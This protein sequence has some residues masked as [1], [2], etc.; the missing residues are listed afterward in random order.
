MSNS[1]EE[2]AI[3][4]P[5][6]ISYPQEEGHWKELIPGVRL[7]PYQGTICDLIQQENV[8]L[9]PDCGRVIHPTHI[10]FIRPSTYLYRV[11]KR[12][13]TEGSSVPEGAVESASSPDI[14]RQCLIAAILA[15]RNGGSF[16]SVF[17]FRRRDGMWRTT[18]F[19]N[20]RLQ[21]VS[22]GNCWALSPEPLDLEQTKQLAMKIDRYYRAIVWWEDRIGMALGYLW[23][24]L[25]AAYAAQTYIS[26]IAL[27]DSLVGTKSSGGHSIAERV[28]TMVGVDP[29]S[30]HEVYVEMVS[31]YRVRNRL[32]HGSAHPRKGKRTTETLSMGAKYSN[33]PREKMSKLIA[34]CIQ[35]IK[36]ALD[37]PTYLSIVQSENTEDRI[38]KKLDTFFLGNLFGAP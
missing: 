12:I 32:V 29:T 11:R 2:E 23:E 35:L 1:N 15:S 20:H 13:N 37:N 4:I 10:I 28:A 7:L 17:T 16:A 18:G 8:Y 30:R 25:T 5:I 3:A 6:K 38:S 31:L 21:E 33:I 27:I 9:A 34:L 36:S 14:A 26:L 24:G 19:S 22:H